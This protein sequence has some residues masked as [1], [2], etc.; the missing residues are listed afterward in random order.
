MRLVVEDGAVFVTDELGNVEL[1]LTGGPYAL[2]QVETQEYIDVFGTFGHFRAH[3][4][5]VTHLNGSAF[6]GT[7]QDLMDAFHSE[8]VAP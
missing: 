4:A 6:S 2:R 3:L 7:L 8:L 1:T 5:K